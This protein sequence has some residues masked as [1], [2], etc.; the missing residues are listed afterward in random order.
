[1]E[2]QISLVV[3]VVFSIIGTLIAVI[4]MR[5]QRDLARIAGSVEQ[6]NI[7]IAVVCSKLEN[8]E[9]RL[10]VLESL[11]RHNSAY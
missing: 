8:H 9:R 1:M 7:K 3:E 6:L 11:K 2:T 4:F 10:E 5:A